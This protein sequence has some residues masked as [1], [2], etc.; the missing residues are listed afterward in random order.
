M[1]KSMKKK[2]LQYFLDKIVATKS[3]VAIEFKGEGGINEINCFKFVV[4]RLQT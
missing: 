1:G 2:G 4:F 3:L